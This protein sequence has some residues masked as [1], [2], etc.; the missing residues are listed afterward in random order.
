MLDCFKTTSQEK[1]S[2]K[3]KRIFLQFQTNELVMSLEDDEILILS[4]GCSLRACG[5]GT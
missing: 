5:V 1:E 2:A 4:G 3:E